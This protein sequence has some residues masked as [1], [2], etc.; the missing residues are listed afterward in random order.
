MV[1]VPRGRMSMTNSQPLLLPQGWV[2]RITTL[3]DECFPEAQVASMRR[4]V[5]SESADNTVDEEMLRSAYEELVDAFPGS[6]AAAALTLAVAQAL[7]ITDYEFFVARPELWQSCA[8][9][10]AS[11]PFHYGDR[12]RV[13]HEDLLYSYYR[14]QVFLVE[15]REGVGSVV[16][17]VADSEFLLSTEVGQRV[18]E[19]ALLALVRERLRARPSDLHRLRAAFPD[20]KA[21]VQKINQ[22]VER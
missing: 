22:L 21:L 5:E 2:A 14:D 6:D 8:R 3:L 9:L 1:S 4:V 17:V 19:N 7:P 18:A 20:M 11:E 12:S 15:G 16:Q 13:L 10:A